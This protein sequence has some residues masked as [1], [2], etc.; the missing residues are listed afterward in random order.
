M[1]AGRLL[2]NGGQSTT[3]GGGDQ[4][5][6]A[7]GRRFSMS[8]MMI[9]RTRM[10]PPPA[11]PSGD[12]T[13]RAAAAI[14][15]IPPP[16]GG[17][18]GWVV[19][20]PRAD[21]AAGGPRVPPLAVGRDVSEIPA[22][23]LGR[24]PVIRTDTHQTRRA[25]PFFLSILTLPVEADGDFERIDPVG[26]AGGRLV[27]SLAFGISLYYRE[28]ETQDARWCPL[29]RR[30]FRAPPTCP[31]SSSSLETPRSAALPP[32]IIPLI[33]AIIALHGRRACR[34]RSLPSRHIAIPFFFNGSPLECVRCLVCAG[35]LRALHF[36]GA[37]TPSFRG[38]GSSRRRQR[39]RVVAGV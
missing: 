21:F 34:P 23:T 32:P 20:H 30:I 38:L 5:P 13:R 26:A 39:P 11:P 8:R 4:E 37:L 24:R 18:L 10:P 1:M 17:G 14:A 19:Y 12:G 15:S 2:N 25:S 6:G 27:F 7:H 22:H 35:T 3:R 36:G 31:F 29:G 16:D 9:A 33:R 28:T